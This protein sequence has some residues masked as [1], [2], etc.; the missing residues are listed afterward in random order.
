LLLDEDTGIA[1]ENATSRRKYLLFLSDLVIPAMFFWF[2][3][4]DRLSDKRYFEAHSPGIPACSSKQPTARFGCFGHFFANVQQSRNQWFLQIHSFS[5]M[6]ISG[7]QLG[8]L[9]TVAGNEKHGTGFTLCIFY[10]S[11]GVY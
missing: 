7:L 1:L 6:T 5:G 9:K 11:W 4:R 10:Q 2:Q 8:N 3:I